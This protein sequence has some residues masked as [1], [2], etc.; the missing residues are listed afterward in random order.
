MHVGRQGTRKWGRRIA[1]ALALALALAAMPVAWIE[2]ACVG[3]PEPG[4]P[5]HASLLEPE[6]RRDGINSYLTYP[7]WSIVHAYEDLAAVTRRSSESDND[8]FGAIGR[9]WSSLCSITTLA[10]SRGTISNEYRVMLHVIGLSFAAEMGVKGLYEKTIGRI[11]S[12]FRGSRKTPEDEFA[13]K[14]AEEYAGFLRQTPWYEYPFAA[15]LGQFWSQTSLIGGNPLRKMERRLA[16]TLEWGAKAIYATAIGIGA[17]ATM[18][19]VLRIRSVIADLLP[20][21]VAADPRITMIRRLPGGASVIET[22]RYRTHTEIMRGLA[23][24]GRNH[25]EIAGNT[26]ILVTVISPP[27]EPVILKDATVLLDVPVQARPGWRRVGLDVEVSSLM[28]LMRSLEGSQLQL[29]HVYD[30]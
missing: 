24:R 28:A 29:E 8:Y 11:S 30:Y 23:A 14:V 19:P 22:D 4:P 5:R 10:S 15:R 18:P 7:E 1:I 27:D 9:Y 6:H 26:R 20:E 2:T 17:G 13:L 12:I 21:D 16:L 3:S 25:V